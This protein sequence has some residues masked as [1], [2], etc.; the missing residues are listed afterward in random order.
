MALINFDCPE[1][2]HNLEVD[3]RGAGFIIK[4]PEC[5]N[6]FQIPELPQSRRM[7]KAATGVSILVIILLL[8]GI[9]L[10]FAR[11]TRVLNERLAEQEE[12]YGLIRQQSQ[13]LAMQQEAEIA[14]LHD[15]VQLAGAEAHADLSDAALEAL[16]EVAT[17]VRELGD[18]QRRFLVAS[19]N[20]QI[21][22][23]RAHMA[24]RVAAA[25]N[26]L[27]AP[28]ILQDVGPGRGFQGRQI[29]FPILPGPDGQILRQNA[30]VTA[31]ENDRIS[32]RFDGGSA[33]YFLHELHPGVSSFVPVDPLM[34]LPPAQWRA[35]VMR[36]HQM[37]QA[38]REERL[39]ELRMV[40]EE[41]TLEPFVPEMDD[42]GARD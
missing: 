22:L 36:L 16:D 32:F 11:E 2:G 20:E 28:P 14:R 29:I 5:D 8:L 27:P 25:R 13:S 3:E 17:L 24:Q 33:T 4:C 42:G 37:Q 26:S 10:Y 30:E 1:C 23:L 18:T 31:A 19:T 35:E 34:A 6:P 21:R 15:K 9:N 40:V 41:H 38:Q 12:A 39:A 7:I